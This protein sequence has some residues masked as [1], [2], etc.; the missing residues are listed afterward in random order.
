[1][2]KKLYDIK[3]N[4]PMYFQEGCM[5]SRATVVPALHKNVYY[6]NKEESECIQMLNG[7]FKFLYCEKDSEENFFSVDYDDSAWN[8]IDVPSMWQYRGYGKPKYPNVAYPIPFNPPFVPYE[9]PV[10]YYRKKFNVAGKENNI[11]F[12]RC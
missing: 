3:I 6:K 8:V 1:M 11:T 5:K 7:D 9:N 4:N 10:G 12:C 2:E